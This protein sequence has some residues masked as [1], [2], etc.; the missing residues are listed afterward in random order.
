[1]NGC[2][3][4]SCLNWLT[5]DYVKKA[6][7]RGHF[8][9]VSLCIDAII[10]SDPSKYVVWRLSSH[11]RKELSVL[12]LAIQ[13]KNKLVLDQM[14]GLAGILP[15][16]DVQFLLQWACGGQKNPDV[17]TRILSVIPALDSNVCNNTLA[18]LSDQG[19]VAVEQ[20]LM[21][22]ADSRADPH[23]SQDI[24]L[25]KA[26]DA[27]KP[28]MILQRLKDKRADASANFKALFLR[29]CRKGQPS[30]L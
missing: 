4:A 14:V 23:Y 15:L 25:R 21:L 13:L 1:F 18:Y 20:V 6:A 17:V 22:L 19:F 16:G 3:A 2:Q 10:D 9:V 26:T 5:K 7:S 28:D 27:W 8:E 12:E 29:A 24:A 11:G 30:T